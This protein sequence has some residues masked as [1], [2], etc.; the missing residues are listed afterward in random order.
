[1][2]LKILFIPI[3]DRPCTFKM[4]VR[5][6]KIAFCEMLHPDAELL[7]QAF[8]PG[9]PDRILD[10]MEKINHS[11]DASII[12][13]D[14]ILYG[15]LVAS[16]RADVSPDTV[17]QRLESFFDILKKS[18]NKFGRIYLQKT[19]MRA[20]PTY[21]DESVVPIIGNLVELSCLYYQVDKGFPGLSGD[22]ARL[23]KQIPED[24][25]KQYLRARN[26]NH[27]I[28]K[29]ILMTMQKATAEHLLFCLDDSK[30]TGLNVR[31]KE[32]L[33]NI[34]NKHDFSSQVSIIPGTDETACLLL[35]RALT[36]LTGY[37]P[38]IFPVFSRKTG[39]SVVPTYEDRP[40]NDILD[41]HMKTVK[42]LNADSRENS[43]VLIY[44]HVPR[45]NQSEAASQIVYPRNTKVTQQMIREIRDNL[46]N[47]KNVALVDALYANGADNS[48]MSQLMHEINP[49][50]LWS[51]AAWNT[52]GNSIGTAISHSVIRFIGEKLVKNADDEEK[53]MISH[54]SLILE[55]Y[56]DDWLYQSI[57]RQQLSDEARAKNISVFHLDEW[58]EYFDQLV[59]DKMQQAVSNFLDNYIQNNI[60]KSSFSGNIYNIV[61]KEMRVR[62]PWN[63]L[64]EVDVDLEL[65]L[66]SA[67]VT[68][69]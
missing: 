21:T 30:T 55:R 57:V 37:S 27:D 66:E 15:G 35:A 42:C 67:P 20:A 48:L 6:A 64:F 25:L 63:R 39:E 65:S 7:G 49:L 8:T 43:D 53:L 18:G 52:A 62:L 60:I 54:L 11:F 69:S 46:E 36:D 19:I 56:I 2:S 17:S 32:E 28:N 38:S 3:D 45:K 29:R 23:R 24:F 51:F 22:I 40:Y 68:S 41:L 4:P 5:M 50:K 10:W 31:E 16:R 33:E 59:K 13:V 12:S 58:T 14:M 1:M 47:D 26:I 61:L 9:N 44:M 34:I